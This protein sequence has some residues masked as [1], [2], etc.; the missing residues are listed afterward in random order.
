MDDF[1]V[2]LLLFCILL[3]FHNEY[4]MIFFFQIYFAVLRTKP[5]AVSP[6]AIPFN[7]IVRKKVVENVKLS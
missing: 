2:S 6:I 5:R 4:V 1:T 7:F 3:F